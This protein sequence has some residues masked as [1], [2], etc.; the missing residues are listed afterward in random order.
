[1]FQLFHQEQF[2]AVCGPVHSTQDSL[3]VE[4]KFAVISHFRMLQISKIKPIM[5]LVGG[6]IGG[7]DDVGDGFSVRREFHLPLKNPP[8][9]HAVRNS[10]GSLG[11]LSFREE[12]ETRNAGDTQQR[13]EMTNKTR[14][15]ALL[16]KMDS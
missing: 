11:L 1:M 8:C 15:T 7:L 5:I 12:R 2:I 6:H 4:K 14:Q 3:R 10:Y 9:L 16:Q 13:S